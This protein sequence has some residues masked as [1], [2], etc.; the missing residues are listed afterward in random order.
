MF[1]FQ[2]ISTDIGNS[3]SDF[4]FTRKILNLLIM[5]LMFSLFNYYNYRLTITSG[6]TKMGSI[7]E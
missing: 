3:N 6:P 4:L 5:K 1:L 7:A 2:E